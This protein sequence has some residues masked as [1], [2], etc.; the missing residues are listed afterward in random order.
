[1]SG[2]WEFVRCVCVRD[3]ST[4]AGLCVCV[5]QVMADIPE[6][7]I[8]QTKKK[9]KTLLLLAPAMGKGEIFAVIKATLPQY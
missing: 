5:T 7:S 8:F 3:T 2:G 9:K 4:T 6:T 1:M